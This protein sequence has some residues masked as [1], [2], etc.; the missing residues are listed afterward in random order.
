[1]KPGGPLDGPQIMADQKDT[2]QKNQPD[3]EVAADNR[4]VPS[5]AEGDRKTVEEDLKQKERGEAAKQGK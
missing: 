3:K 1:M 2:Q 4:P 5:Q